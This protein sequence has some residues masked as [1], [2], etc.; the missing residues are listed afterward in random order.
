MLESLP[1]SLIKNKHFLACI[2]VDKDNPGATIAAD[3]PGALTGP[4]A[5]G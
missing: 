1:A 5:K 2:G 4:P 3:I